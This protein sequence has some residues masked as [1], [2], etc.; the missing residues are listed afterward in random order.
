MAVPAMT[1]PILAGV[2][3]FT[4][5]S[6][7]ACTGNPRA[8]RMPQYRYW[9]NRLTTAFENILL[10]THFTEIS[11]F[12]ICDAFNASDSTDRSTAWPCL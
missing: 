3:D 11:C 1:A 5:G 4:C 7:F 10:G 2:A 8:R 9:G 12:A 6:R